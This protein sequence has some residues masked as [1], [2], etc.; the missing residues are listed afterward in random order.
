V[1]WYTGTSEVKLPHHSTAL[2]VCYT[3]ALFLCL[4]L[5]VKK[6]MLFLSPPCLMIIVWWSNSCT[7]TILVLCLLGVVMLPCELFFLIFFVFWPASWVLSPLFNTG[8]LG[9]CL[10]VLTFIAC[11]LL[12]VFVALIDL[13][14]WT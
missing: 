2:L 10:P 11:C 6:E 1:P 12:L 4:V 9:V 5:L 7:S 3:D 13:F 14:S 8:P